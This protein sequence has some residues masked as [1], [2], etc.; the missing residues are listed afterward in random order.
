MQLRTAKSPPK[1]RVFRKLA[2]RC[3]TDNLPVER[4]NLGGRYHGR[5]L[6]ADVAAKRAAVIEVDFLLQ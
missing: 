1:F 4:F 2:D 6:E 3:E 5:K